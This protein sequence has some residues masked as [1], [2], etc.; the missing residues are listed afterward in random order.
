MGSTCCKAT[1][2]EHYTPLIDNEP[3]MKT[4]KSNMVDSFSQTEIEETSIKKV[5]TPK[6]Y[7]GFEMIDNLNDIYELGRVIGSGSF[8]TVSLSTQRKTGV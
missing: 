6:K 7:K 4:P 8:G 1:S 5:T 3:I 2:N